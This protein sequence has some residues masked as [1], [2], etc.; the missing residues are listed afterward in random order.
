[1]TVSPE[2]RDEALL[3][4]ARAENALEMAAER[5]LAIINSYY[6][7]VVQGSLGTSAAVFAA[8][9][10][11]SENSQVPGGFG[12]LHEQLVRSYDDAVQEGNRLLEQDVRMPYGS[13]RH[14]Y[15]EQF[16]A[17]QPAM[18]EIWQRDYAEGLVRQCLQL[19][20]SELHHRG[21]VD[22]KRFLS[23]TKDL[24]TGRAAQ[25]LFSARHARALLRTT[26]AALTRAAWHWTRASN[27]QKGRLPPPF[28]EWPWRSATCACPR[29]LSGSPCSPPGLSAGVANLDRFATHVDQEDHPIIGAG[30]DA[31]ELGFARQGAHK[32]RVAR[33]RDLPLRC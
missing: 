7:T 12:P 24:C 15:D 22:D 16:R 5:V 20:L 1:M 25:A 28:A 11:R 31:K 29:A 18:F 21:I 6:L 10:M 2:A 30:I 17:A 33:G 4:G 23:L 26:R 9:Q 32:G 13:L 27:C 8:Y 19:L 3:R 14:V